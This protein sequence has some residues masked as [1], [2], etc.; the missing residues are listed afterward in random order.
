[1]TTIHPSILTQIHSMSDQSDRTSWKRKQTNISKLVDDANTLAE[2]MTDL[3][4]KMQTI[5]DEIERYR[6]EMTD[7]CIHPEEFLVLA[8]E[9]PEDETRQNVSCKFC[10]KILSL[11][12]K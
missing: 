2:E 4:L 7:T 12:T 8:V 5:I 6:S 10:N 3:T 11:R 1:M 9:Q